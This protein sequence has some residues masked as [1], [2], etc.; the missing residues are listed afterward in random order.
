MSTLLDRLWYPAAP[1]SLARKLALS[2]LLIPEAVFRAA[3]SMRTA[4]FDRGWARAHRVTG[5]R[6]VSVGNLNVGGAGKTPVT[7]LL[8]QRLQALGE[9]VAILS[10]GYG[11]QSRAPVVITPGAPRPSVAE[12]G[13]EPLILADRC[14]A[15]TVW[16]GADRVASAREATR[17][18]A[19]VLVLDDGLQHR[20]LA[21]DV[22]VVVV[23]GAAQFGNGHLM[24]R[25]PLREPPR[26]LSRASIICWRLLGE[27]AK[28]TLELS[29]P[30]FVV[31][32]R[33]A[34]WRAPDG[35]T[36]APD[37]LDGAR[38]QLLTAVARPARVVQTVQRLGATVG[39]VHAF[40]DHHPFSPAELADVSRG[41]AKDELLV[42]TEKDRVRLPPGMAVWTLRM[43]ATIEAGAEH[44]DALLTRPQ[45]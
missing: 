9:R 12:A 3:V 35:R 6:I 22:D 11:R 7:I 17:A 42:T 28:P 26:A 41:L 27:E 34:G 13:D 4:A 40:P 29:L 39:R 33:A 10:R 38:V 5:A 44:L 25:G 21:R 32:F 20:R 18:G 8:A 1:E 14:P 16:I 43:D 45:T 36:L 30:A 31:R 19:T 15:A 23:D 24:P 37:A 2:P